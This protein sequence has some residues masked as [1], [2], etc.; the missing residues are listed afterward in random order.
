VFAEPL[1]QI[2]STHVLWRGRK[3]LYFGGCDYLRLSRSPSVLDSIQKSL[4]KYGLN[5]AASRK[6]TGNHPLYDKAEGAIANY[7]GS[8]RALLVSNG[9]L[10]NL[11]VAQG[12]A[13]RVSHAFIHEQAH[14]SLQDAA[15][16][17]GAKVQTFK[18]RDAADL[19]AKISRFGKSSAVA[20]LTDGLFAQNGSLAPLVEYVEMLNKK[21][22]LWVDDSHGAGILGK[23]GGGTVEVCGLARR[24]LVQTITFSKGFGVYGGAVL[25]KE[26]LYSRIL[27]ESSIVA[28]NTPL[29]LPLVGGIMAGLRGASRQLRKRLEKNVRELFALAGMTPPEV[30]TPILGLVPVSSAYASSF[31]KELLN[32]KIYP[33]FI[34]YPGGPATGYFRFAV[35][36]E[37]TGWEIQRLGCL[38]A[39]GLNSGLRAL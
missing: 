23:Q 15:K 14:V 19:A 10:T 16:F 22:L 39:T 27:A 32:A 8:E 18:H 30:A 20:V 4:D 6:T 2:D 34:R 38:L 33:C 21:S 35:S 37:H 24:N 13:G 28:G 25:C 26:G 29:P 7:F 3:L 1:E 12:L 31:E 11:I 36:A 9:Y 5:V 17:L